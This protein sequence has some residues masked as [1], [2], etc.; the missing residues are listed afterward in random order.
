MATVVPGA[1]TAS[2]VFAQAYA[3]VG[4]DD[5]T[6]YDA[7]KMVTDETGQISLNVP[8]D[9]VFVSGEG[10]LNSPQV[11]ASIT[12]GASLDEPNITVRLLDGQDLDLV[13]AENGPAFVADCTVLTSGYE[14]PAPLE[15]EGLLFADPLTITGGAGG[16]LTGAFVIY[17]SCLFGP[18]PTQVVEIAVANGQGRIAFVQIFVRSIAEFAAIDELLASLNIGG[19]AQG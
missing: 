14:L 16:S 15:Y 13:L 11:I 3:N 5:G 2:V 18:E 1:G 6:T 4:T 19:P 10:D 17:E 9:F 12:E 8:Q 7:Y